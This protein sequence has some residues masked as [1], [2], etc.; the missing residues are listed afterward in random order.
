MYHME[1]ESKADKS[2]GEASI[3]LQV[4]LGRGG[5]ARGRAGDTNKDMLGRARVSNGRQV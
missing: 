5:M 3:E 1:E 4:R 2:E